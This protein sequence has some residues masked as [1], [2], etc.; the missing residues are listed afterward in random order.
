MFRSCGWDGSFDGESP[1]CEPKSCGSHPYIEDGVLSTTEELFYLDVVT[2][3]CNE[4]FELHG[5]ESRYC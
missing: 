2:M 5:D 3:T 1:V 4:G